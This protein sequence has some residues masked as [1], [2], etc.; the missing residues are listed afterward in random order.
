MKYL[1]E[2][3]LDTCDEKSAKITPPF[4]VPGETRSAIDNAISCFNH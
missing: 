3:R 2:R 1:H 4:I